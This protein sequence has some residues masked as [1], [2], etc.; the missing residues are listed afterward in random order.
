MTSLWVSTGWIVGIV[1]FIIAAIATGVITLATVWGDK[2]VSEERQS[3]PER[4]RQP[5]R[6]ARR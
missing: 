6:R 4:L 1:I 3:D 2:R 5:R